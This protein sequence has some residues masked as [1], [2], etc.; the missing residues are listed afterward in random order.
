MIGELTYILCMLPDL[1][2]LR[3][4][5]DLQAFFCGRGPLELATK[6]SRVLAPKNEK[7]RTHPVHLHS[8]KQR[9]PTL[10]LS[11][12]PTYLQTIMSCYWDWLSPDLQRI[13]LAHHGCGPVN[14]DFCSHPASR[15]QVTHVQGRPAVVDEHGTVLEFLDYR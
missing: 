9:N 12:R 14:T 5:A 7:C 13:I 15:C 3:A 10:Y 1:D 8:K 6:S 11:C 4:L 2:L